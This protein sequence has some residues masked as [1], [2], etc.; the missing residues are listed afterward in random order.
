MDRRPLTIALYRGKGTQPYRWRLKAPNG[1]IIADSAEGYASVGALRRA[2]LKI[3]AWA[4][5][6]V[7][8][9]DPLKPA[10]PPDPSAGASPAV[11]AIS[12]IKTWLTTPAGPMK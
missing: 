12:A 11:Q 9:S 3:G 7:V 8:V 4:V 5:D 6:G 2:V 10:R 1:R